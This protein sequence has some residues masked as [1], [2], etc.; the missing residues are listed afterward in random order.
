MASK[1]NIKTLF[2]FDFDHTLIDDNVDTW[3]VSVRPR[4]QDIV[5]FNTLRATFPCWTDLIDHIFSL[6]SDEGVTETEILTHMKKLRLY[7]QAMK[8]VHAV[9]QSDCS[10]A[11]I[12]SD[13]NTVFIECILNECGIRHFFKEVY[14]NPA[15]FDSTGRLHV[16]HYHS[17]TCSTCKRSPNLCKGAVLK[18]YLERESYRYNKVV[19]IGDGRGDFCPTTLLSK[20]DVVVCRKGYALAKLTADTASHTTTL[21]ATTHV[22]DFVESLGDVVTSECL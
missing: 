9:E 13:A 6:I 3:I 18:G 19:V 8:A 12:I 11:I 2:V 22:I 21:R 4:L 15:H 16:Q 7:D 17:H 20:Q 14:T 1:Q 10:E 5:C